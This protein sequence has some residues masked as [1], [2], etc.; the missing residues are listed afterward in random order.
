MKRSNTKEL[1]ILT[2]VIVLSLAFLCIFNITYSYFTASAIINGDAEFNNIQVNFY[3]TTASGNGIVES[4][5][6][7]EVN[8]VGVVTRGTPFEVQYNSTKLTSVGFKADSNSC[9]VY[10]RFWIDAYAVN[11]DVVDASTNYGKYFSFY[12]GD[13]PA[14]SI[15]NQNT[16]D[17]TNITYFIPNAI[18]AG[19]TNTPFNKI[20]L[21]NSAPN[22]MLGKNIRI[23]IRFEAI[24]STN[25]ACKSWEMYLTDE[26]GEYI[27]D[28]DGALILNDNK[29]IWDT[30]Q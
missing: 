23:T 13:N 21:S 5:N 29:G 9:S 3:Y 19:Q 15:K 7:L 16:D 14:T 8:P 2:A 24:Q 12:N 27:E 26:N 22:A 6:T 10:I 28:E 25:G 4:G 30:W 11:N 18:T 1:N 17:G 20:L